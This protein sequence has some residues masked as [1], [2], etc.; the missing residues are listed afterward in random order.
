MEVKW[1]RNHI[2]HA[3]GG[4]MLIHGGILE[5]EKITNELILIEFSTIQCSPCLTKGK[6]PFLAY[7]CSEYVIE[8]ERLNKVSYNIYKGSQLIEGKNSAKIK[9]E[10]IY[11]F[12]GID[13]EYNLKN[14]LY[15]LKIGR[16]PCEWIKPKITSPIP[17]ARINATLN[18]YNELNILILH[19]GRNDQ[20]K[21]NIFFDIWL[22][23][24]ENFFWIKAK[25]APINPIERTEH[26]SIIYNNK[27]LILGGL[28]LKKY[29]PMDF[30]ILNIDLHHDKEKERDILK[31]KEKKNKI[32]KGKISIEEN[33]NDI[34]GK[35]NTNVFSKR[36]IYFNNNF[37]LIYSIIIKIY[38]RRGNAQKIEIKK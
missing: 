11:L 26:C 32:E 25:T 30:L 4:M 34:L 5:T 19:G 17:P 7:H 33:N 10:G 2:A 8:N 38:I 37:L 1:R 29:N 36:L 15:I 22:F 20:L 12:G 21:K 23:D 18:F 27:M 9:Y 35:L 28:N 3:V 16:K 24:L 14:D 6:S 13:E 31:D